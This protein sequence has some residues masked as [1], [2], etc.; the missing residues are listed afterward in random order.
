MQK[1][2]YQTHK[3]WRAILLVPLSWVFSFIAHKRKL[4]LQR[5]AYRSTLPIIVVGN[6]T[7]GGTGK[8]PVVKVLCQYLQKKGYHPAI[9]TRG[10]GG[11]AKHY[12]FVISEPY[13]A[14][15]C[16][17]EPYMLSKLLKDIPIVVSPK[18]VD[19]VKWIERHVPEINVIISDDGLQHYAMARDI[20][21]AVVD[22]QR[23][24]GNGLCL[25]AGPLREPVRRLKKV[26][27]VIINGGAN[28]C[29]CD[30]IT[31]FGMDLKAD[32]LVNIATG[33]PHSIAAFIMKYGKACY[34]IAGIG[35]PD[36]FFESLRRLG[37]NE[38]KAYPFAD[39]YAYNHKDFDFVTHANMPVVMTH[40]DAVKCQS[41][42]KGNWYYLAVL[43]AIDDGFFE[44]VSKSLSLLEKSKG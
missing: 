44:G 27:F 17:D 30:E 6:I 38:L 20:E 15:E 21:I 12:P 43:P 33:E 34:A 14:K 7:V 26:D 10:F 35:N 13:L 31:A 8:T 4:V 42:A 9:I 37:F 41:F 32:A 18:R 11:K 3:T 28:K 22:G 29:D 19:S 40:K 25:P 36:R 24:F 23:M 5:H 39:H 2:W 16:G 1:H